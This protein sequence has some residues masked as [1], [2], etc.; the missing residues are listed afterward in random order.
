[1]VGSF[2][3]FVVFPRC[4]IDA[5]KRLQTENGKK[6][7]TLVALGG[8]GHPQPSPPPLRDKSRKTR[9]YKGAATHPPSLGTTN[10][11]GWRRKRICGGVGVFLSPQESPTTPILPPPHYQ[12]GRD[13][14]GWRDPPLP[15]LQ[16]HRGEN[17]PPLLLS[18]RRRLRC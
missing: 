7:G 12:V 4:F 1:M 17:P 15:H 5:Q 13:T 6:A 9:L 18:C 3:S 2:P 14:R 16:S 11:R 8:I 10:P